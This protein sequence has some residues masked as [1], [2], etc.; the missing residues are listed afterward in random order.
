MS[1]NTKLPHIIVYDIA[2]PK[3]L[4]RIHRLLK[5]QAI[6]L[7]YSVFLAYLNAADRATLLA[8]LD[9]KIQPLEDD[10]RLYPLPKKP[11][12]T[13]YGKAL[14]TDGINLTGITLPKTQKPVE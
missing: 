4:R 14:W 11:A 13:N 12:W 2:N 7:Q 9:D 6:P 5:E 8:Q 3:R 1:N 10:I